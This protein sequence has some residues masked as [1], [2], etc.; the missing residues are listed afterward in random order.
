M[1]NF[2][3]FIFVRFYAVW[4]L[5]KLT[6]SNAGAAKQVVACCS[7]GL[8]AAGALFTMTR[9]YHEQGKRKREEGNP[10][11]KQTHN[12]SG[13]LIC[14]RFKR[15]NFFFLY[16]LLVFCWRHGVQRTGTK[17]PEGYGAAHCILFIT[18]GRRYIGGYNNLAAMLACT[19][20]VR[21]ICIS[22]TCE[23]VFFQRS[24]ML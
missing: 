17:G 7:N 20:A 12:V 2:I 21:Y 3:L 4:T 16:Q 6:C 23:K 10:P 5:H 15:C 19:L 9:R 8:Q 14:T 13:S 22:F 1:I 18:A 24:C 11:L